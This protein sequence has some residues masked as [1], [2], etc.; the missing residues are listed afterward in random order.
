MKDEPIKNNQDVKV[1]D[2]DFVKEL[3]KA[4]DLTEFKKERT[5]AMA[6]ITASSRT[7]RWRTAVKWLLSHNK[8]AKIE[9]DQT[10]AWINDIRSDQSNKFASTE[11]GYFRYGMKIPSMVLDTLY[12]VDPNL[13]YD[14]GNDSTAAKQRRVLHELMKT[15][16]EYRIAKV[17]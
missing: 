3:Q 9:S 4:I 5:K 13:S 14:L 16:P 7:E 10:I 12:L 15:F 2:R 6:G 11:K 17:V 1:D 8:Q